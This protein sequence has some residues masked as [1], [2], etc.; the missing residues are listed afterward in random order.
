MGFAPS[1]KMIATAP[2][3]LYNSGY[4]SGFFYIQYLAMP[5]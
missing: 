3:F 1:G 4:I 5:G 2:S